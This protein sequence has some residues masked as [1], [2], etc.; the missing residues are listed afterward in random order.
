MY[1]IPNNANTYAV[2]TQP[3]ASSPV[4]RVINALHILLLIIH[5][6]KTDINIS[7]LAQNNNFF[8]HYIQN[9]KMNII[10]PC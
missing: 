9:V 2:Y 10:N 7:F 6:Y 5:T 8:E 4:K 3:Y 1:H